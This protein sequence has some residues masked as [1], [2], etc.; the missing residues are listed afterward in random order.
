M[1]QQEWDDHDRSSKTLAPDLAKDYLESCAPNAII[2]TFGD[3]D[4]YPLWYAQEVE[5]VRQDIR[6][7]NNSLLGIDW[8][9]NQLR[10]KVNQADSVDVIWS[11]EQI[12]GHNREYLRYQ[13]DPSADKNTYYPLEYIMGKEVLGKRKEDPDTKRD[14]GPEY[15]P[16]NHLS[17]AVDTVLVRKN[18]T[19]NPDDKVESQLMITIDEQKLSGG[20]IRS[21]LMI[22]NIIAAN[23]WKRPIYFTA[24]FG[25]LG[26]SQYLRKDGLAYRLVPVLAKYPQR[27]WEIENKIAEIEQKIRTRL[28][29]TP[30]GDNNNAVI[31]DNL[32]NKFA[33]GN[34]AKPG[35]YFDEENR[36]HLLNIRS[37]YAEAAGNLADIGRKEDAGKLIDKAEAGISP[38]NLP[39][40]MASRYNS[41]DQTSLIYLEACYKAGKTDVAEKVRKAVRKDLEQQDKY[42]KYLKAEKP[43]FYGGTLEGTEVLL[44]QVML[45]VLDALEAKYAPQTQAKPNPERS[46]GSI[47]TEIR[48]DSLVKKD[49]PGI[50]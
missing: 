29:G 31:F 34:A 27:N 16:V 47:Q 2:F 26:F 49:S 17:V 41:H 14:E 30:I 44:N 20:L 43:E 32:M 48:P 38:E 36:R 9:I 11:P 37:A 6:I 18:G 25:E 45:E 1:A 33:F 46:G 4:T 8:Y 40:G 5:G 15:F 39:F 23:K 13:L 10:Y 21:D 22:L 28:G 7:I 19:V 35:V 12:E 3:N 50:K 42:Y 24:A